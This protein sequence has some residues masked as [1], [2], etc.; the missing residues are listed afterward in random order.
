MGLLTLRISKHNDL[1]QFFQILLDDFQTIQV[2]GINNEYFGVRLVNN[3]PE[4]FTLVLTL[5]TYLVAGGCIVLTLSL[6]V[7]T[8]RRLIFLL[9]LVGFLVLL[10]SLIVFSYAM[11]QLTNVGVGSFLG[12]GSIDTSVP[13]VAGSLAVPSSWGPSIGFYLLL[14]V[15]ITLFFYTFFY[16]K[17][18]AVWIRR[19]RHSPQ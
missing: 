12:S 13:G 8:Y 4:E 6:F 17:L 11:S 3:M 9:Q 5:I 18:Q 19:S 1:F 16:K 14:L 2:L 10:V 7:K 15:T